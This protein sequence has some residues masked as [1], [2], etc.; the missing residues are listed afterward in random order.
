MSEI[1]LALLYELDI[2][3]NKDHSMKMSQMEVI[4][5]LNSDLV[6]IEKAL[7]TRHGTSQN[8]RDV[9]HGQVRT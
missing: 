6:E 8:D 2:T 7:E 9:I 4:Q 5:S 1:L 3:W